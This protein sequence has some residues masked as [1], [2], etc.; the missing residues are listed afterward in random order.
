MFL[1]ISDYLNWPNTFGLPR[2]LFVILFRQSIT[3]QDYSYQLTFYENLTQII[4]A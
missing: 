1:K 2:R 3:N 4:L